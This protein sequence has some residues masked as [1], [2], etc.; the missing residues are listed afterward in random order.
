MQERE[1]AR[2]EAEAK[3]FASRERGVTWDARESQ[4]RAALRWDSSVRHLGLF[5]DER[6][7]IDC[8]R[9]ARR[10]RAADVTFDQYRRGDYEVEDVSTREF[11]AFPM[12]DDE[13][14]FVPTKSRRRDD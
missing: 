7:A 6:E 1:A 3:G 2:R 9:E 10:L 8:I 13:P 4:W 14:V 11:G 5:D 12:F